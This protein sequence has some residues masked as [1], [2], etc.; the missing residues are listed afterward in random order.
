MASFEVRQG[1]SPSTAFI[2]VEEYN[3]TAEIRKALQEMVFKLNQK[4]VASSLAAL[5]LQEAICLIDENAA[6]KIAS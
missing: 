3:E 5:K 6:N 2:K 4:G 1:P